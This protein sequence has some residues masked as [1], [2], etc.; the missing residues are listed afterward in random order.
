MFSLPSNSVFLLIFISDSLEFVSTYRHLGLQLS[1]KYISDTLYQTD[2]PFALFDKLYSVKVH[3][4]SANSCI[5]LLGYCNSD[6]GMFPLLLMNPTM[7]RYICIYN[8]RRL[9]LADLWPGPPSV[10]TKRVGLEDSMTSLRMLS[11]SAQCLIS[12]EACK[13]I[14]YY[15]VYFSIV[16]TVI[17]MFLE[18]LFVRA[19]KESHRKHLN[20]G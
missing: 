8:D 12:I 9:Q 20:H 11:F 15:R 1:Q 13:T 19:I 16:N 3:V 2:T 18:Y 10:N 4:C 14:F 5:I 6:L 7:A 17:S